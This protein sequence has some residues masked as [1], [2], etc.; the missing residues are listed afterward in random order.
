M[1]AWDDYLRLLAE[2]DALGSEEAA[3]IADANATFQRVVR[4][5]DHEQA[6]ASRELQTLRSQN[7]ELQAGTRSLCRTLGVEQ[8]EADRAQPMPAAD[9]A[10]AARSA[11]YDLEQLSA[12]LRSIEQTVLRMAPRDAPPVTQPVAL[13]P[14]PPPAPAAPRPEPAPAPEPRSVS[15]GSAKVSL[16]VGI[17]LGAALALAA[18][19]ALF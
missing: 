10:E 11:K 18:L 8:R 5:L 19:A 2:L 6:R 17:A 7:S 12:S 9:I 1:S 13:P 14:P 3:G 16:G 15:F 4:E